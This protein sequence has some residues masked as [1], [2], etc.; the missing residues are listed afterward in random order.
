LRRC[1]PAAR[2]HPTRLDK[3]TAVAKPEKKGIVGGK[4]GGAG[5]WFLLVRG[6][7][8]AL[9]PRLI[10]ASHLT[11]SAAISSQRP[12]RRYDFGTGIRRTACL[13][14][15]ALESCSTVIMLAGKK[16]APRT[17]SSHGTLSNSPPPELLTDSLDAL[18]KAVNGTAV[19]ISRTNGLR[20]C[21]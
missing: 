16:K 21:L 17:H 8:E 5:P 2:D 6:S 11:T 14:R 4:F 13:H 1:R 18:L 19:L 12:S 15:L 10:Q 7:W 20:G 3:S 9:V